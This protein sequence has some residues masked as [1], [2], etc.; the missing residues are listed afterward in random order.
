M[1]ITL[2]GKRLSTL[3]TLFSFSIFGGVNAFAADSSGVQEN[4]DKLQQTKSCKGCNLAGANLNR[5]ELADADLEGADLSGAKVTL[6]NLSRANLRNA[7][8]RGTIFGGSDLSDADLRGA[9]LRGASLDS[10]YHQGARFDGEFVAARPYVDVGAPEVEK[11][12]FVADTTTP[13]KIEEPAKVAISGERVVTNEAASAERSKAVQS[14][15]TAE[16]NKQERAP[17]EIPAGGPPQKKV[18]PPSSAMVDEPPLADEKTKVQAAARET[19]PESAAPVEEKQAKTTV[20]AVEEKPLAKAENTLDD[21]PKASPTGGQ[22]L[23]G[24]PAKA[25]PQAPPVVASIPETKAEAMTTKPAP[26]IVAKEAATPEKRQEAEALPA[27]PAVPP[28]KEP[29][30]NP[31]AKVGKALEPKKAEA[32]I[33]ASKTEKGEAEKVAVLLDTKKCYGCKLSDCQLAG[34]NLGKVDLEKADLSGCDLTGADLDGANLKGALLRNVN[35][36]GAS[37]KNVDFYKADVSGADFT[38]AKLKGAMFDEAKVEDAVG[39]KEAQLEA[40]K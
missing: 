8:L 7:N 29:E 34:K 1:N 38:G 6:S 32:P 15:V 24:E 19:P 13:K 12:V 10:S 27:S 23:V 21:K 2:A 5:L 39:L 30:K 25:L 17:A 22:P 20:R 37:L 35:F 11:E 16:S 36:T 31:Q 40:E 33:A 14:S 3:L 18:V 28:T 4:L 26:E 9:D